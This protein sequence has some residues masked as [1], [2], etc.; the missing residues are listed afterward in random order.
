MNRKGF[1]LVELLVSVVILGVV[2]GMSFPVIRKIRESNNDMQYEDYAES[3]I[4]SAKLYV[5]S[6]GHDMFGNNPNGCKFVKFSEMYSLGIAKDIEM[7][8]LSCNSNNTFVKVKKVNN[9]YKFTAY[10]G[11]GEANSSGMPKSISIVY[12]EAS[13]PYSPTAAFCT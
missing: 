8:N 5:D 3:L 2:V 1:T 9:K 6:Y 12:P 7:N 10:L 13:S 4:N 11:C